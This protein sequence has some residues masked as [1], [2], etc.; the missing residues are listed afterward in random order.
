VQANADATVAS[1]VVVRAPDDATRMRAFGDARRDFGNPSP[2]TR[3]REQGIKDGL[4]QVTDYCGR[5]VLPSPS[6]SASP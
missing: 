2:D 5:P 6:S 1:I 4:A 3:T